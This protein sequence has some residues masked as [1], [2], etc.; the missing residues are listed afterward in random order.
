M[1]YNTQYLDI[2]SPPPQQIVGVFNFLPVASARGVGVGSSIY[3]NH[4]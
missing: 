1:C 3:E 4:N 2:L